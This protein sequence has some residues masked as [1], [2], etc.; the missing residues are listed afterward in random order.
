MKEKT[1]RRTSYRIA[2]SANRY[3]TEAAAHAAIIGSIEG[4][5][6]RKDITL[7]PLDP[8]LTWSIKLG[9]K[10]HETACVIRQGRNYHF[11]FPA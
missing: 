4:F 5:W 7:I 8:G 1:I 6:I 10:I 9:E 11:A 2:A 3:P